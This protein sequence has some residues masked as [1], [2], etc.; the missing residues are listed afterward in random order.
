MRVFLHELC[1]YLLKYFV[2]KT[3]E[4]AISNSFAEFVM[5]LSH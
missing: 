2:F 5:N 1:F 4:F 3:V